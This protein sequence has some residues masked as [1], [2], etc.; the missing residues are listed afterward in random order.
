MTVTAIC[1]I[2]RNLL[3]NGL[4]RNVFRGPRLPS[5]EGRKGRKLSESCDTEKGLEKDTARIKGRE[6]VGREYQSEEV[7]D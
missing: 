1:I 7:I 6:R 5:Q 2:A 3:P 4:N